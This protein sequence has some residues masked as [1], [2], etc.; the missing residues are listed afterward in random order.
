M[1]L[2]TT[3]AC[4]ASTLPPLIRGSNAI[5]AGTSPAKLY[6]YNNETTDF[7]LRRMIIDSSG[8]VTVSSTATSITGF[9]TDIKYDN[10]V[11]YSSTGRAVNPETGAAL[12]TFTLVGGSM[13]AFVP[14]A[15]VKRIYFVTGTGSSTTLQAFDQTT[16]LPV[17]SLPIPGVSGSANN[18]IRWGANGL[19]FSYLRE[20]NLLY[21]DLSDSAGS[22]DGH[23]DYRLA[24]P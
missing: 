1:S 14:D 13:P 22:A 10:G 3:T 15:S 18:L 16:F 20:S 24:L 7:G 11:L 12:G 2:F 4:V 9:G 23:V 17:G 21:P 6:G 8:V 19:A 5:E